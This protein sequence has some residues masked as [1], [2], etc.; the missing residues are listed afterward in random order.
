VSAILADVPA[1]ICFVGHSHRPSC[2]TVEGA[3]RAQLVSTSEGAISL[4]EGRRYLVN[5]GS[6][7]Q[8]RDGDARACLVLWDRERRSV[9][10]ERVPYDVPAAQAR[11]RAAGLPPL[12]AERLAP[13]H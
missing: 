11:I 12:L 8:P 10:L 4:E 1:R 9:Q 3:R 5:A 6:V 7:G 2:W 13:G